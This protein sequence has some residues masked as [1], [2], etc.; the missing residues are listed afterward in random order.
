MTLE[1][2]LAAM[3]S[4]WEDLAR[5]PE[6][7]ESPAWHKEVLDDRRQRAENG[8]AR[9]TEWENAK[10]KIRKKVPWGVMRQEI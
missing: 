3:E 8:K 4:L 2:K 6:T 7:I 1:E 10:A 9:F 5:A